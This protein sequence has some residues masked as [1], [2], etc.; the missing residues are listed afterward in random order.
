MDDRDQDVGEHAHRQ[1]EVAF[2]P[3][4]VDRVVQ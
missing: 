1:D 4:S 3:V 2:S